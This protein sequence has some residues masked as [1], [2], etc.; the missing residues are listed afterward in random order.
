M[1]ICAKRTQ[2]LTGEPC[3]ISVARLHTLR[4]HCRSPRGKRI[5]AATLWQRLSI[6]RYFFLWLDCNGHLLHNPAERLA[7][8][9]EEQPLP[10]VLNESDIARF[11]ETPDTT[12]TLGLCDRARLEVLYATGIRH[13]EAHKLNLYT[14]S[15]PSRIVSRFVLAKASAIVS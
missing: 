4:R 2:S 6:I 12:T 11:I 14:T 3:I 8:P 7:F 9:R 10:H 15:T 13:S 1:H 5:S